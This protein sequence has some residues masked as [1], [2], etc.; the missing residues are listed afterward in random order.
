MTEA[1]EQ[2][3]PHHHH[4]EQARAQVIELLS[5]QAVERELVSRSENRKQDVV[6]QLVQRQQQ[7]AL[8]QRLANFHPADIAF[9]LESLAP[10]ARDLAWALVRAERRGAVLLETDAAVR[11][12]LIAGMPAEE[13]VSL[14][15]PLDADDIADLLSELPEE[16]RQ[17]VLARLDQTDQVEV[18]SVLSFPQGTVGAAMDLDF[19]A[20]RDDASLEAVHRLLRRRKQLPPHTNQLFVVDRS[21]VLKGLLSISKLVLEEP[22]ATVGDS[23]TANPVFFYTDDAMREATIAFEKYDLLSAPVVN[24]HNQVVGRVT[25]DA[26]LDAVAEQSQLDSLRQAGLTHKEDLYGPV[27][28]SGRN[29]WPWLGLNLLTSFG[30][31]RVIG[32]FDNVI[33]QFTALATLIPIIASLGGN[34][35]TQTMELVIRALALDQLGPAQLRRTFIKEFLVAVLNGSIWGAALGMM[36]FM[37]YGQIKL[38]ITIYGAM[39]LELVVAAVAGVAIPVGLKRLGRDPILGSSVLLTAIT[40]TM[41]FFIFLGLA[42]IFLVHR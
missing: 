11:R 2:Q 34:T 25:V 23:M 33:V 30:S 15:R 20:V 42:T 5:R 8:E 39:V 31:S 22:E 7:A 14:V 29:R 6:A 37:L 18:R 19:V 13:V 3:R 41:G 35:G 21:N 9:V 1:A 10:E 4:L 36:T 12:V 32:V 40:D 16:V 27:L 28:Q 26:V 17:D 38:S 24:L